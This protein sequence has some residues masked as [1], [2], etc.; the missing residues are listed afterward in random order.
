MDNMEHHEQ[1]WVA[2]VA[3][4][5]GLLALHKCTWQILAWVAIAGCYLMA[6]ETTVKR[7]LRLKDHRGSWFGIRRQAATKPNPSLGFLLCPT[8]NQTFEFEKRL[9]QEKE[10]A[11][12]VA[13]A[14]LTQHKAWL[15]LVTRVLPRVTYPFGLTRFTKQQLHKLAIVLDNVFFPKLGINRH[16]KCIAVYALLELGGI[17]FPSIE[18]IHNCRTKRLLVIYAYSFQGRSWILVLSDQSYK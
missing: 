13:T 8:G 15:A 16:M 7:E 6:S 14:T 12:R 4:T 9:K 5:G 3:A 1:M 10:C 11:S 2:L 18:T 17:S